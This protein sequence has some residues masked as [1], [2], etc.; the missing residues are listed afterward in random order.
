MQNE[1]AF[2][3]GINVAPSLLTNLCARYAEPHRRYH[4]EVHIRSLLSL[5]HTHQ[6]LAQSPSV[7]EAAI[8]FHDAVYDTHRADNEEA[9]ARL[10]VSEL[11]AAGWAIAAANRVA[12]LISF[13]AQH[14]APLDDADAWLFLDMD[15][16]V[17]AQSPAV[18]A[19]Y[20]QAIRAEYSWVPDAAYANGRNAVLQRF[21][22]RD[23]IYHTP[24]LHAAWEAQART[25]VHI[26]LMSLQADA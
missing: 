3:R 5:L 19:A 23:I 11:T 22:Q 26:E 16:S 9:S 4:T 8:W 24:A 2:N 13:T 10:A 25:N 14:M 7:L 18:Y 1:C 21:L 15:L 20:A 12:D 6:H 17:L